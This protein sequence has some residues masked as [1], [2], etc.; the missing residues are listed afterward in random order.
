M[1]MAERT[2]GGLGTVSTMPATIENAVAVRDDLLESLEREVGVLMRRARRVMAV[3]AS[4][5]HADLM[6]TSYLV[7]AHINERG[8][9]RASSVADYF[10]LDKGAVSRHVQHLVELGLVERAP[11]PEDRR[12]TLL[13]STEEA[14]VRMQRV[15]VERRARLKERLDEWDDDGLT[16]FVGHLSRYNHA[17]E[18]MDPLS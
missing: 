4:L 11:D 7:L 10:D 17:L 12:A 13:A 16:E 8:S 14:R 6:P 2:G 9:V 1:G 15:V 5:V 18:S 3:R